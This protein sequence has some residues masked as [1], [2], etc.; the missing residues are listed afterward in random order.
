MPSLTIP[1]RDY[2][3]IQELIDLDDATFNTFS[4][5]LKNARPTL[6][7]SEF[8][9]SISEQLPAIKKGAI[10]KIVLVVLSLYSVRDIHDISPEVLADGLCEAA[11]EIK[12]PGFPF[13]AAKRSMLKSRVT[14]LLT[15]DTSVGVTA[16]AGDILTEHQRIFCSARILSD[17]RPIFTQ[18]VASISG[19]VLVHMLQIAYHENGEHKEFYVA[20]DTL[21]LK[22]LKEVVNRAEQKTKTIEGFLQKSSVNYLPVD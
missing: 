9:E 8:I 15:Y 1:K 18:P 12:S 6:L 4:E 20:L 22:K 11:E 19:A 7:R 10:K 2:D 17:I 21:D 13:D 3:S 16:K 5:A 14:R